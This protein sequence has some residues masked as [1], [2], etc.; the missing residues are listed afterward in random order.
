MKA[1]AAGANEADVV[2]HVFLLGDLRAERGDTETGTVCV[3]AAELRERRAGLLLAYLLLH[4]RP[5]LREELA[6]MFWPDAGSSDH[7]RKNLTMT[8]G[9]LRRA[10]GL[11]TGTRDDNDLFFEADRY[12]IG[13]R[14]GVFWCDVAQFDALQSA[15]RSPRSPAHARSVLSEAV[16]LYGGPLLPGVYD[17]WALDARERLAEEHAATITKFAELLETEGD[18]AG[19]LALAENA[20]KQ[21]RN[22]PEL[23]RLALRLHGACGRSPSTLPYAWRDVDDEEDALP[24]LLQ[25]VLRQRQR[26]GNSHGEKEALVSSPL[27]LAVHN[28]IA[29]LAEQEKRLLCRLAF[30]EGSVTTEQAATIC[31][32]PRTQERLESLC[33][34]RLVFC[35]KET[36]RY[37]LSHTARQV[38]I[39]ML[40]R[41]ERDALARRQAAFFVRLAKT[42]RVEWDQTPARAIALLRAEEAQL[43]QILNRDWE[44]SHTE[45]EVAT[46]LLWL[47]HFFRRDLE[48]ISTQ[49]DAWIIRAASTVEDGSAKLPMLRRDQVLRMAA[50]L[51]VKQG[52][53]SRAVALLRRAVVYVREATANHGPHLEGNAAYLAD[54]LNYIGMAAHHGE[55]FDTALAAFDEAEQ[56]VVGRQNVVLP[57]LTLGNKGDTLLYLGRTDEAQACFEQALSLLRTGNA[58]APHVATALYRLAQLWHQRGEYGQARRLANQALSLRREYGDQLAAVDCL[59]LLGAM[60]AEQGFFAEAETLLEHCRDTLMQR[61]ELA[62]RAAVVG[63]LGDCALWQGKKERA[64]EFY[65]EALDFWR[66]K[67]HTGWVGLSLLRQ[68]DLA[69]YAGQHGD[70]ECLVNEALTVCLAAKSPLRRAAALYLRG[71]VAGERGEYAAA[72]TDLEE[73]LTLREAADA[74]LGVARSLEALALVEDR[75]G[76]STRAGEVAARADELRRVMGTPLPPVACGGAS[77]SQVLRST[78]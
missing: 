9:A 58:A 66:A 50:D 51:A 62:T 13:L 29:A 65:D 1:V 10:L 53:L 46:E 3:T 17:T 63:C 40:T 74:R 5:Q 34:A 43:C 35:D 16:D 70:A 77:G 55:D 28:T 12:T 64:A 57:G 4:E 18:C 26:N 22:R 75:A 36:G 59:R 42:A 23:R 52:D 31:R 39:A 21:N 49:A 76:N 14:P 8:F 32:V 24:D 47:L 6:D 44:R 15:I 72:R 60:Q 48:I 78:M 54:N 11:P 67:G 38:A 41:T 45:T 56:L 61:G 33:R 2:W 37:R 71:R 73:S 7:A 19:A 27:A 69:L 30:F 25:T 68:G 20:L